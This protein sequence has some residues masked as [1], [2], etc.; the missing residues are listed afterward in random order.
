M[1]KRARCSLRGNSRP[2]I[3]LDRLKVLHVA[4]EELEKAVAPM[5]DVKA[6]KL[7]AAS[8]RPAA[9]GKAKTKRAAP[10]RPKAK[11]APRPASKRGRA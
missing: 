9:E 11:R 6:R 8:S 1:S 7:V 4:P 2:R 10:K 3:K 5:V